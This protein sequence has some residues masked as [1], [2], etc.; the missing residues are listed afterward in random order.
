LVSRASSPNTWPETALPWRITVNIFSILSHLLLKR[1]PSSEVIVRPSFLCT[2]Q[3]LRILL[4]EVR[5]SP[6][7]M[8]RGTSGG[9]SLSIV[10]LGVPMG[11]P[12]HEHFKYEANQVR[13][14]LQIPLRWLHRS[15]Y[16]QVRSVYRHYHYDSLLF[17][18]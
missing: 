10:M 6:S 5:S 1:R 8:R 3:R 12:I 15:Q 14:A 7:W 16:A 9:A 11:A 18:A 4:V 13:R 2:L 17:L